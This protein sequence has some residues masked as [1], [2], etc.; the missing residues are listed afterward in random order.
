M[1]EDYKKGVRGIWADG[2]T[3]DYYRVANDRKEGWKQRKRR[4]RERG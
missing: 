3:T 4:E 1:P 2:M